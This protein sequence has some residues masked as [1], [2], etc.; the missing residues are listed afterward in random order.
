MNSDTSRLCTDTQCSCDGNQCVTPDYRMTRSNCLY[1]FFGAIKYWCCFKDEKPLESWYDRN[2][3]CRIVSGT[4]AMLLMLGG[5][6]L[7]MISPISYGLGLLTQW[8]FDG[9]ISSYEYWINIVGGW[10]GFIFLIM[11]PLVIGIGTLAVLAFI[12]VQII[13]CIDG[14]NECSKD[15]HRFRESRYNG[16]PL[17]PA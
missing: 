8:V 16:T 17:T 9:K 13:S 7:V 6:C 10:F 3:C 15:Y 2:N 4:G 11:T 1:N 5:I 14:C 12:F